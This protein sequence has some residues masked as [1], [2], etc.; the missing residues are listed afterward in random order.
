[1]GGKATGRRDDGRDDGDGDDDKRV[2][3]TPLPSP[4]SSRHLRHDEQTCSSCSC[5]NKLQISPTQP[6]KQHGET[7]PET[8]GT[9]RL[10]RATRWLA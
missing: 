3:G 4:G 2:S 10:L 9:T 1:M 8:S 5:T 6:A 7:P